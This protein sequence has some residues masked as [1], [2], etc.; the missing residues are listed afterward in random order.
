[1][2]LAVVVA[3]LAYGD[4][5][6]EAVSR[7]KGAFDDIPSGAAISVARAVLSRDEVERAAY[8]IT[9]F[10]Q[11]ADGEWEVTVQTENTK[12]EPYN[13][14]SVIECFSDAACKTPAEEDDPA[15]LFIRASLQ[16]LPAGNVP[17]DHGIVVS[18]PVRI[19]P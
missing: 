6:N 12:K 19:V 2:F 9:E 11:N 5:F 10:R 8:K 7:A 17:P 4:L 15:A 18:G 16:V 1:M 3:G 13:G 14:I